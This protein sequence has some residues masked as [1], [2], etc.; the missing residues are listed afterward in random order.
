MP[1]CHVAACSFPGLVGFRLSSTQAHVSKL[2]TRKRPQRK[3]PEQSGSTLRLP[4]QPPLRGQAC[5]G[6]RYG[7]AKRGII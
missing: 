7:E 6:G 1:A 4:H 2:S 5:V 3:E